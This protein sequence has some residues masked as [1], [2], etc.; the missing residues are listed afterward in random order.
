[1]DETRFPTCAVIAAS[2]QTIV[3]FSWLL[4]WGAWAGWGVFPNGLIV[5]SII[6]GPLLIISITSVFGLWKGRM[7]D[8]I[9]GVLGNAASSLILFFTSKPLCIIP[10]VFFVFLLSRNVREFY[11][12]DY[13]E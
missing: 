1:M 12:R 13:Y 4:I 5:S 11:T 6:F 10:V 9:T 3:T 7:F 8:W 2:A